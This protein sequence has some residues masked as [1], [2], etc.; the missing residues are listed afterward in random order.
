MGYY[1]R[2]QAQWIA[3]DERRRDQDRR[4]GR[5]PRAARR[6]RRRRAP[7]RR[8]PRSA[9]TT[10]SWPSS[11]TSTTPARASGA[12]RSRTSRRGT[13]TGPTACRTAPAAPTRAARTTATPT[14]TTRATQSGS[15]ILCENQVL[16]EQVAD[17][18]HA[19]HARL[20]VRPRA[21]PPHRRL[22]RDPAD[23]ARRRRPRS[24][25]VDLTIEVAGRTI[26]QSFAPRGEP[27]HDVR[28]RRPATPTG[29]VVQ[30]RQ[31]VDVTIDYVYPAVYRTPDTFGSSFAAVGG[32]VL[33]ANRTRQE[34]SVGQQLERRRSA[35]ACSAPAARARGLERRRPP[36][37]RPG[38]PHALPGRRHQAQRRGP[39]LR[40]HLDHE[41]RPRRARGHGPRPTDG[42]LLVADS[43][44]HVDPPGRAGRRDDGDRG[45]AARAGFGGD[46]GPAAD[47]AVRPPRR[48]RGR[49][50][51]RD[52]RRRPGQQPHP[53]DLR[54]AHHDDRRHRRRRLRG[55]RRPGAPTAL[56]DEPSDVAVDARRRRLRRRP[57]Q[58]RGA[59][60]RRRRHR[61]PR[62]PATARPASAATAASPPA[63][64]C[65]PRATSSV[66]RA[67]AACSSPTA[68]TTA[69]AG[70]T[71]TARSRRSRATAATATAATAG[72]ATAAQPGHA[73]RRSLPLRDGGVLIADAGN[74]TLR[75]VAPDGHDPTVAGNGTPG[76]RGD[77]GAGRRRRGSTS[78]RRSRSAPTTRS[79]SPTT[80][81]TACARSRRRCRACTLGEFT[82]ASLDGALA[83]RLRPQRPPPAHGRLADQGDR[84]DASAT[85][86]R[87]A[88]RRSRDGDGRMTTTIQR[89]A[90]R[91]DG[92]RRPVR[93]ARRRWRSPAAT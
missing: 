52:L 10:P 47:A 51:R 59:P 18:R 39:E 70:S 58:P 90:R 24:A 91:A 21:R 43:A 37:L 88:D 2:E 30:G 7:T 31:K 4:R 55:R 40:R 9:S 64:G 3:A 87:A 85:T 71:P 17:R 93:P 36:H 19:V 80:A 41:D 50:R 62:W 92:D 60:D 38:R 89:A 68:A 63:R 42:D 26:T 72:T 12:R 45:H 16:G 66:A 67:T 32:A 33:S 69:C 65:A 73:D 22:A 79:T 15:I 28:L 75:K 8:S 27:A 44:A 1:D 54:R 53:P 14:A 57:R 46:G 61:S 86:P 29:A 25:R 56:L 81:T 5:R 76:S 13:T 74:A 48:R 34:I 77:G 11:P 35:T 23:R 84:A 49:A 20:P 6:D 82:I 78:R 83:V